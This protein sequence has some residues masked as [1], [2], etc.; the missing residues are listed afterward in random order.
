MGLPSGEGL[1]ATAAFTGLGPSWQCSM[2]DVMKAKN[3]EQV[4][5][6]LTS[7]VVVSHTRFYFFGIVCGNVDTMMLPMCF[8]F[9]LPYPYLLDSSAILIL[10]GIVTN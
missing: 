4:V 9:E 5:A 1:A 2:F 7:N 6:A 8:S 3:W 10:C